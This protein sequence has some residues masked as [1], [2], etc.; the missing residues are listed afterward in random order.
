MSL[1]APYSL[2]CP[3]CQALIFKSPSPKSTN[4]GEY[5]CHICYKTFKITFAVAQELVKPNCRDCDDKGT[6]H[7][8]I[9]PVGD[10]AEFYCEC[11]AGKTARQRDRTN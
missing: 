1:I 11:S 10:T 8:I 4:E 6:Y 7:D 9:S 3:E 2:K 5:K